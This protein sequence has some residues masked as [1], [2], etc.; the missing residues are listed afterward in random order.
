MTHAEHSGVQVEWQ[1]GEVLFDMDGTLIDSIGAVED[2]WAQWAAEERLELAVDRSFHG[3]TA[4]DLV[5]S[6]LP[7]ERVPSAVSRL[8]R[9]EEA[10]RV[11]VSVLPGA[12]E[13][14]SALPPAR[15]AVVTSATR[16]AALARL[17]AAGLPTP[18]HLVTGDDV[19]KGKPDAEPYLA[20]RRIDSDLPAIA[21]EDTV[22]G[23]RSARAAGCLTVGIA[24]TVAPELLL[25]HA[26]AV[27]SSLQQVHVVGVGDDGIRLRF[28][29]AWRGT[30]HNAPDAD[31]TMPAVPGP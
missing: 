24:G 25:E 2:A 7:A 12:R 11:P 1:V 9:L 15:W 22:A 3:R 18:A 31:G 10:P 23:I 27:I 30:S 14:V 21:F 4:R 17:A 16:G 19:A 8:N 6:L 29:D 28:T 20:G 26:D 13:L 5:A